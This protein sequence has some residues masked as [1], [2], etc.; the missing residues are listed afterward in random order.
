MECSVFHNFCQNDSVVFRSYIQVEGVVQNA[1]CLVIV[2]KFLPEYVQLGLTIDGNSVK[3]GRAV[4]SSRIYLEMG[5]RFVHL[6][7]FHIVAG[8]VLEVYV[9][10]KRARV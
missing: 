2:A 10:R 6:G 3:L 1:E 8:F 4:F 7:E 5:I 9:Y